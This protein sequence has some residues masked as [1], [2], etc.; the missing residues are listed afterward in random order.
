MQLLATM[1]QVED[2]KIWLFGSNEDGIF[3]KVNDQ[4]IKNCL[5]NL[6]EKVIDVKECKANAQN[7][8][9]IAVSSHDY[10]SS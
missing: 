3:V 5:G 6:M 7:T 1:E 9:F 8:Q 2:G 4:R 10:N